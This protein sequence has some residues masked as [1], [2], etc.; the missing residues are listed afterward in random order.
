MLSRCAN[1]ACSAPFRY[2]HEGRIFNFDS[3]LSVEAVH[4]GRGDLNERHIEHYWLC[5]RC[6]ETLTVVLVA[7]QP[8]L[9]MRRAELPPAEE[10]GRPAVAAA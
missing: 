6:A 5:A 1:P 10:A 8:V 9:H 4:S 3:G 2:L 7:R